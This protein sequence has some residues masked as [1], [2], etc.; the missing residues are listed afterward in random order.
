MDRSEIAKLVI[1]NKRNYIAWTLEMKAELSFINCMK[2]VE[3]I[4]LDFT[5]DKKEKSFCLLIRCLNN[6]TSLFVSNKIQPQQDG[7]GKA[8]WELPKEE[9]VGSGIQAHGAAG[10]IL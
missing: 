1:L 6:N 10:S 2:Y 9:F 4:E 3:G 5:G 7:D 8:L